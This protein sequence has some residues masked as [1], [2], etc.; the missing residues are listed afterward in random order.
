MQASIEP[1]RH[2]LRLQPTRA[3]CSRRL[4]PRGALAAETRSVMP[5]PGISGDGRIRKP[6]LEMNT[7]A[8]VS[9][10]SL[11]L[12]WFTAP[13]AAQRP[14]ILS[15]EVRE[16][17]AVDAPVVALT[18]VRVIDGTGALPREDQTILIRD[19]LIVSVGSADRV[20]VP[21]GAQ[22]LK[23][24]AH[25][26]F[27]GIVGMHNHLGFGYDFNPRQDARLYL[28]A[29]VTTIRTAGT[30]EPYREINL[31]REIDEGRSLGPRI[32]LTGPYLTGREAPNLRMAQIS[33]PEDGRRFVNHW[34]DEGVSWIK[35]YT[36]IRR[37]DLAAVIDQA[38]ARGLR[39]TGHLCAVTAREAAELGIDNI[40]HGPT[41]T[42]FD[43]QKPP[44]VCPQGNYAVDPAS[45]PVVATIR[46]LVANNVAMTATLAEAEA[47]EPRRPAADTRVFDFMSP[48]TLSAYRDFRAHFDS[49]PELGYLARAKAV[50]RAFVGARGLLVAGID[51]VLP[52]V[53]AGFADQRN[54][55][56]LVE[57]GFAAEQALQIMTANGAKL[58]G[59]D[60]VV[61]TL[62][63]GKIADL[64]VIKGDPATDPTAIREVVFVFKDGIG[65]DSPRLIESVRRELRRQ[66]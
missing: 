63:P 1:P 45:E 11:F 8:Y 49:A 13:A 7:L 61:G 12:A 46:A 34:A 62:E 24:A 2:N 52:G 23:L 37:Q 17:V 29:G 35:V 43:P 36:R 41:S 31:K 18:S 9:A 50:F 60:S 25:T 65:Y 30:Y 33:N 3:R 55:E 39:V 42:D 20:P 27:P 64:V 66:E 28:G 22:V 4:L 5:L 53:L 32:H 56:L 16:F 6:L 10:F 44:D 59:V 15:S 26:V 19:R 57:A 38:H 40:E 51:P 47:Y 14:P 21:E 58:L 54:Y 48:G